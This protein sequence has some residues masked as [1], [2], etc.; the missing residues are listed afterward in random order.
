MARYPHP[1][2]LK[3][4]ISPFQILTEGLAWILFLENGNGCIH[5]IEIHDR[6]KSVQGKVND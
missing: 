1:A 2:L 5:H 3:I 4:S 6:G